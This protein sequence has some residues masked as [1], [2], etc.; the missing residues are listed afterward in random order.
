[1]KNKTQSYQLISKNCGK[2][3]QFGKIWLK[4]NEIWQNFPKFTQ[5]FPKFQPTFHQNCN[6]YAQI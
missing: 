3:A 4:L 6:S 5:T 1:M 2:L